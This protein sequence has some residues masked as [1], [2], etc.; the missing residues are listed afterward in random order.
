MRGGAPV[1]IGVGNDFRHDDGAGPAVL[2][3]LQAAREVLPDGVRLA[4]C[5]GEPTR[6]IELWDHARLAI[7]VDAAAPDPGAGLLP[8]AVV[9]WE[10]PREPAAGRTAAGVAPPIRSD[11]SGTHA[12]GPGTAVRLARV[13]DRLPERL[14]LLAIVGADFRP[15]P[16][17]S[18]AVTETVAHVAREVAA[19]LRRQGP[20]AQSGGDLGPWPLSQPHTRL[21]S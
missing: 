10:M 9:R 4:V 15:G 6:M 7:V 13:L 1:V 20:S 2:A 12:L 8:G 5:D 21:K 19:R 14:L 3:V 17:L 11:S 16:G 18:E